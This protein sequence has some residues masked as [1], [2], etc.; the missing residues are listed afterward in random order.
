MPMDQLLRSLEGEP[1]LSNQASELVY[2]STHVVGI[3]LNDKT[4]E[5]LKTKCWMY[6]PESDS[7]FYRA[8]VFS[9]YAPSNVPLPGEQWS[10]MCEISESPDR[11]VDRDLIVEETIQGLLS[12]KLITE[13]DEIVSRWHRRLEYGYPTPW[14]GRD[15]VVDPINRSL[16]EM[17]IYSRGRFGAW[18]YEV[19]NQDYSLIQGV[20]VV[21]HILQGKE[22]RTF[23]GDMNDYP[24]T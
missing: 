9:N 2:S 17:G 15:A 4:P 14:Y 21:N 16:M 23:H 20:E 1:E 7:S 3:G 18:K 24:I 11:P 10:L 6:F 19:S 13:D 22:E 5:Q 12:S 8:T